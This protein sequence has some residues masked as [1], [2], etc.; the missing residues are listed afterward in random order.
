MAILN[1]LYGNGYQPIPITTPSTTQ[2]KPLF[3]ILVL[4]V[5][6]SAKPIIKFQS[7]V[8]QAN[9]HWVLLF[10]SYFVHGTLHYHTKLEADVWNS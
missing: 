3:E 8:E 7:S 2:Q 6:S 10:S 1:L 9:I 4:V 5:T